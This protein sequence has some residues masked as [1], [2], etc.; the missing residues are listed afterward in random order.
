MKVPAVKTG[1]DQLKTKAKRRILNDWKSLS[2]WDKTFVIS[3]GVL[4]GTSLGLGIKSSPETQQFL[5]EKIDGKKLTIPATP[6]SIRLN[7]VGENKG[8]VLY[9]DIGSLLKKRKR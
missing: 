7:V 3:Q 2:N 4:L 9:L 1:V 5:L 6:L 8:A